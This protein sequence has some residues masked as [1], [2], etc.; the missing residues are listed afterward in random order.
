[1]RRLFAWAA[2]IVSIAA[3][4]RLLG[5]RHRTTTPVEPGSDPADEL[6]RKLDAVRAEPPPTEPDAGE[7][8]APPGAP[9]ESL[10]QRRARVHAKAQEALDEMRPGDA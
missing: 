9:T 5:R 8:P 10:E 4:A 2:G 6:R 1:M 7:E 3:L